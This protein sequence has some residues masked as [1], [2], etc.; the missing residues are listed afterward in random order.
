MSTEFAL[1]RPAVILNGFDIYESKTRLCIVGSNESEG[2]YRVLRISRTAG[3]KM[4]EDDA[5][6]TRESVQKVV[7]GIQSSGMKLVVSNVCGIL[8]F[9]R[10][11]KGYYISLVTKRKPVALLGGH[12]VY[13]VEDTRLLS[14]AYRPE[15]SDE[16]EKCI[17]RFK[18]V[19]L[20]KNFYYSHT[21]DITHTLQR[22]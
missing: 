14:I 11:T 3:L 21:Y 1:E 17:T 8:G 4:V 18:N 13:H 12:Y 10:F 15:R 20:T 5:S 9:V 2:Y 16:E 6:H 7:S 19:D 22:N